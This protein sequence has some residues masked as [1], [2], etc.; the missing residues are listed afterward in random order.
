M[1]FKKGKKKIRITLL[2]AAAA[3]LWLFYGT[4]PVMAAGKP[5][6]V[7]T[8]QIGG[9]TVAV[10]AHSTSLPA[11]DD[12][13]YYLFAEPLYA[14]GINS[15]TYVAAAPMG[16][17][18][19]FSVPLL[20]GSADSRLYSQFIV[21]VLQNG[22]YVAVSDGH[23]IT[24]PE[25]LATHTAG[26]TQTA[27]KKGLLVDSAKLAGA[28]LNDLGVRH[29]VYNLP[30]SNIFGPTTDGH[31]PTVNYTYNGKNY[32]FNGRVVAEYD[33]IFGTLSKKGICITA[34]LLNNNNGR[35]PQ[36]LHPLA[37]TGVT[38][39]YY[40]FNTAEQGGTEAIAAIGSFLGQRY[41]GAHGKVDNWVVGN[42][43][44]A[45]SQWNYMAC[46]DLNTYAAEYGKAVRLFYNAI[47]S[48]NANA[49]VY[50]CIDQQWNRRRNDP[51]NFDGKALLDSM[52]SWM[53]ATGNINWSLAC[54]PYPVPLT[55]APFWMNSAY[56]RG[57]VQHSVSSPFV[58]MENIEVLTD[59]MCQPQM[60]SPNGQVRSIIVS[61]TGYTAAQ[62]QELQAA[63]FAHAYLTAASNQHIDAFILS[64]ETDAAEEIAQG[65]SMG[66]TNPDGSHK[67]IYDYFKNIDTPKAGPYLET[68]KALI[69][70]TDWGQIIQKR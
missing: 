42:E 56:Y 70:I 7:T 27:S 20:A 33:N 41:S 66:L 54:H 24:N 62:G 58:T 51:N 22:K 45:K 18:V 8:C 26:R 65:L 11:S 10:K 2:V 60:L 40:A 32:Q 14:S 25:A 19:A 50:A 67:L 53:T 3:F 48:E 46:N 64:R 13:I 57:L 55:F 17:D 68:A 59:Y 44:N 15:Q 23:F 5:C 30:I 6:A 1:S 31:Y 39:N 37:R 47:R 29:A 4:A 49:N 38:S 9:G 35:N 61:E 69:G 21:G 16:V 36:L 12:G 63:C 28:E 34:V 52:N 43:V